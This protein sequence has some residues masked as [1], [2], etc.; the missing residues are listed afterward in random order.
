MRQ[1]A[2]MDMNQKKDVKAEDAVAILMSTYN[3]G[4]YIEDQLRTIYSQTYSD[5]TLFIRDDGSKPAFRKKLEALQDQYGFT[6]FLGENQGFLKSFFSLAR[7]VQNLDRKYG[8]YSFADQDD[9]WL[10]GKL[11]RGINAIRELDCPA[12]YCSNQII[13]KNGTDEGLRFR[14]APNYTLV[15]SLCGNSLSGCTMVFNRALW[16]E[17]RKEGHR[18]DPDLLNVRMH[19]VWTLLS[20]LVLGQVVY[21]EGSRIRYRIHES[22]TVGIRPT[23]PAYRI[24][25]LR[26]R[27]ASRQEQNG[28]S[29]IAQEL[30]KYDIPDPQKKAVVEN[31]A[32]YRDSLGKKMKLMTDRQVRK[33]CGEKRPVFLLKTLL[34]WI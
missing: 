29:R 30:L 34:N 16:E 22:N 26:K 7:H 27:L 21:D 5:I 18:P 13:Y 15:N 31:F 9:L 11:R 6:I 12:L 28:R 3:G 10:P 17:M 24:K 25:T 23:G 2:M 33:D 20:A 19:D 4:D 1:A 14:K 32:H 8:Y